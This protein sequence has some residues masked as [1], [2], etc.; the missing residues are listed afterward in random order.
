MIRINFIGTGSGKTSL[1]RN[2]TS[3]LIE[4]DFSNILIDCGDGISKALLQQQ[5]NFNSID[6][7]FISHLH[8]DHFSGIASFVTQM[9]LNGRK[10]KLTILSHKNLIPAIKEFVNSTYMFA[11]TIGFEIDFVELEFDFKFHLNEKTKLMIKK[12]SHI[13]QKD[14]T[15]NYPA[16]MFVSAS[17]MLEIDGKNI[18]YT[19]D[20]GNEE[21]FYLFNDNK[22]DCMITESTHVSCEEIFEAFNKLTPDKF[23]IVHISDDDEIHLLTWYNNLDS[24]TKEK[25][26]IPSDGFSYSL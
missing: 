24:L 18:F 4:N 21:D 10:N 5:I 19:S 6:S 14:E 25:I 11:E 9:K 3:F 12:N 7:I 2:H 26:M 20:I 16:K 17:L 13:K 22:F 1:R 8:A 23:F 15:K